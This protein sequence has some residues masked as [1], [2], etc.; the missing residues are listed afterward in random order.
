MKQ[1]KIFVPVQ[2]FKNLISE[3]TLQIIQL[4]DKHSFSL[5]Q[6]KEKTGISQERIQMQLEK[7]IDGN[8]IKTKRTK[9]PIQYTLT[10]KGSSLLHPEN[11]RIMV[12]FSASLVTL[13]ISAS[14]FIYWITQKTPTP[15]DGIHLL[16]ESDRVVNGPVKTFASETAQNVQDPLFSTVAVIGIVVFIT[17]ISITFWRYQKN[18]SQAL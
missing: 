9:N 7:L 11:N 3:D 13:V 18:K 16:Q 14:S 8:V 1:K 17:L 15:E 12:L 5:H 6:L 4:L 10:F 2:T